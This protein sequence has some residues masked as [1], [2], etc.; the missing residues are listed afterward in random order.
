MVFMMWSICGGLCVAGCGGRE[1]KF[2]RSSVK[3]Y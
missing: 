3:V 2:T 1:K